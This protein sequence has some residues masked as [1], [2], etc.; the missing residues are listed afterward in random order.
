MKKLQSDTPLNYTSFL[1]IFNEKYFSPSI[2][3]FIAGALNTGICLY[4]LS[5]EKIKN[6]NYTQI[7]K[8]TFKVTHPLIPTLAIFSVA[9]MVAG[10]ALKLFN[11]DIEP[12]KNASCSFARFA[13]IN[14]ISLFGFSLLVHEL[15]HAALA[16]LFFK[17]SR[18]KVTITH[19]LKGETIYAVS[20][21]MTRIGK[22]IGI[23]KAVSVITAGGFFAS[24]TMCL[25]LN[26]ISKKLENNK[27]CNSAETIKKLAQVQIIS[28][29]FYA[30]FS[31]FS[32]NPDLTNDYTYLEIAEGI[33]PLISISLMVSVLAYTIYSGK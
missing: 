26:F 11:I 20:N 1:P 12:F 21:G 2:E 22:F 31:L 25:S 28:E 9:F 10:I 13:I 17:N 33:H 29:I 14:A 32:K 27:Y 18:V 4:Q 8:L 19:F 5:K 23:D 15:G 3:L 6:L 30:S 16:I 24:S 7:F